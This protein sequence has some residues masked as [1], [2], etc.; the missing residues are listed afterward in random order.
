MRKFTV[1]IGIPAYN[2]AKSIRLLIQDILNQELDSV[3]IRSILIISDGSTDNTVK[4]AK[5]VK[6]PRI[7]IVERSIRL[8]K[9]IRQNEL[10]SMSSTDALVLLDGDV[11]IID[12]KTIEKIVLPV[13]KRQADLTSGAILE[14]QPR[15]V[16][17]NILSV[18]MKLKAILFA[19]HNEGSNVYHCHGPIR[20][21]SKKLYSQFRFEMNEGED[22][23][24]Y[25]SCISR[26]MRFSY[27]VDASVIYRLPSTM[28]DHTKQSIRYAEAKQLMTTVFDSDLVNKEFNISIITVI[29]A[30]F[31]A[32]MLII[33]HPLETFL[34]IFIF[35][36]LRIV[37]VNIKKQV[38][39][40]SAVSTK[41]I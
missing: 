1:T 17:E 18:S 24:S 40:W 21:F 4:E 41:N 7:H 23:Y 34:Y 10:F 39:T 26:R 38:D 28:S 3:D 33:T 19:T 8:G 35:S 2:E 31:R 20:A 25:F 32:G 16:L 30:A 14:S 9:A 13:K 11:R 5:A 37:T 29:K 27:V 36:W 22:M 15:T 6:D 12:K